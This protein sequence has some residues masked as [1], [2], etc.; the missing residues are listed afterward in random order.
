MAES[1]SS[2]F[3]NKIMKIGNKWSNFNTKL[4]MGVGGRVSK[5]QVHFGTVWPQDEPLPA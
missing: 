1:K 5:I 2:V 3:V 4:I